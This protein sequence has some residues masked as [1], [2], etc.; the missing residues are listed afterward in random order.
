MAIKK[1]VFLLFAIAVSCVSCVVA[2]GLAGTL[3]PA[4]GRTGSDAD[5]AFSDLGVAVPFSTS[6]GQVAA[7]NGKGRGA[8]LVWLFDHRGGYAI[9]A[10]DAETGKSMQRQTP[11]PTD[12]DAP[13]FSLLSSGNKYYA[14]FGSHFCEYDPVAQDF[15]FWTNTAPL[16]SFSII[17]DERGVIWSA[18]YPQSGLVSF[19][20]KTRAFKDYGHIYK[21]TWEQYPT[22][23]AIDD[24]GWVY[25][26][27]GSA[28]CQVIAFDPAT[29]VVKSLVPEEKRHHG[30]GEV[31]QAE[32]GRIYAFAG[33]NEGWLECRAGLARKIEG[34]PPARKTPGG[35]GKQNLFPDG[36]RLG[37]VDL[38]ASV[39]TLE[40]PKTGEVRRVSF[41]YA[42]EGPSIMGVAA[43]PDGTICGGT[44]FPMRFFSYD[45]KTGRMTNRPTLG[46]W[47]AMTRQGG[48]FYAGCYTGGF[49]LEWNTARAWVDPRR[50]DTNSNPLF[51]GENREVMNRPH[52][53]LPLPD[54]KTIVMGGTAGYGA[55]GAGMVFWDNKARTKRQVKHTEIIPEHSTLSMVALPGGRILG[56]S[57][58]RPGTGGQKKAAIAELFI[59]DAATARLE[60]RKAVLP[61]AHEYTELCAGPR[62]LVYGLADG[63]DND[64]TDRLRQEDGRRFFVFDPTRREIIHAA[65]TEP[66]FGPIHYQQGYRKLLSGPDNR[67]FILFS[68]CIA[69][70]N[71]ETFKISLLAKSPETI[72]A[73][74]DIFN[75]VIYFACK[76]RLYSHGIPGE[77]ASS[78]DKP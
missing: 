70:V 37:G 22:G 4:K 21:Q 40:G 25:W 53:L 39:L 35:K 78:R 7:A 58:V 63:P 32:N 52:T 30:S 76:S 75:G 73:G 34:K 62:G 71:P 66:E 49:M 28:L 59:M 18:S 61:G 26:G 41:E 42:T 45:P 38:I 11:F 46:Q 13:F 15:T 5:T 55:T 20:P 74:G 6:R 44:A 56:G 3:E 36:S 8:A 19:D 69:E 47:N 16:T 43:A 23:L 14:H 57:T 33:R 54:G 64:A 77:P 31:F 68:K 29:G 48:M 60:W 10:I 1:Q 2:A 9:L 12:G 65:N 27:V 17:E 50:G 24:A 72:T 67:V 51:L